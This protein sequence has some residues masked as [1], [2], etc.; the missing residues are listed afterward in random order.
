MGTVGKAL[1]LLD[2]FSRSRPQAG[3]SELARLA[4]VNKATCYRMLG[5]MALHGLVE[6]VGPSRE[7]RLGPALVRLARVREAAVPMRETLMP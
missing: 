3:L 5:E 4:G 2:L 1:E 7:Y 6:Q